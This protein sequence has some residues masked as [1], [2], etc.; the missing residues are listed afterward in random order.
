VRDNAIR[1]A[2]GSSG[3]LLRGW[4]GCGDSDGAEG[5][6]WYACVVA[7]ATG[8][9]AAASVPSLYIFRSYTGVN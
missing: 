6:H 2:A 7:D 8:E 4:D 9:F 1:L 5:I 3:I